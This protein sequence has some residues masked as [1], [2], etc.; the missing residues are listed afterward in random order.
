MSLSLRQLWY[1]KESACSMPISWPLIKGRDCLFPLGDIAK[2]S[3]TSSL[4]GC[5]SRCRTHLTRIWAYL[6]SMLLNGWNRGEG[7]DR[8]AEG[9]FSPVGHSPCCSL[10]AITCS[11][12]RGDPGSCQSPHGACGFRGTS[13]LGQCLLLLLTQTWC[14]CQSAALPSP[15]RVLW[16]QVP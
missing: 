9:T 5:K 16:G 6:Q 10:C 13:Q 2:A 3:K 1:E 15:H 14:L 7:S 4:L 8:G 12:Y 11:L